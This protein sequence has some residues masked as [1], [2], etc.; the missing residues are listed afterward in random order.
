[1][2]TLKICD[3]NDGIARLGGEFCEDEQVMGF[4]L[5][6]RGVT[7]D[8]ATF[9]KS[10][11]DGFIQQDR[12]I[13]TVK[14]QN[15]EDIDVDASYT[16]LQNGDSIKNNDGIKKWNLTFYKGARWQ[17]EIQKLNNSEA[18][19]IIW[20]LKDDSILVQQLK[21]GTVKGFDV[22]LFTG[23]RK[24]K[25]GAEGGGS[26]LRCDLTSSAMS[27][28]QGSSAIYESN[29][30]DFLEL[31]PISEVTMTVPVLTAGATTTTIKITQ[32]GSNAPMIGL[33]DKLN[34]KLV[35]NGVEEAITN[36][37]QVAENYTFTHA[38][39]VAG[40]EIVFKTEMAGYP[41]Y[42]LGQGY[43]IGKSTPKT[44]A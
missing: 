17:N 36:L 1:M 41:I 3:R 44:V 34:W 27:A 25:T 38:A 29:E 33:T 20:V 8:P 31:Q 15:L 24:V 43:Y 11:L 14:T 9:S 5:T 32:A 10:I 22:K 26:V 2:L 42:V 7:F 23:I 37:T 40:Q 28:W 39:L 30:I 6:K 18:Y 4:I 12:L 21:D 35:R 19:S 13:G 16:D